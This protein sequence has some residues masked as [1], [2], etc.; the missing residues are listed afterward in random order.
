VKTKDFALDVK[1]VGEDGVFSGYGSV[2]HVEDRQKEIV[3]PGAFAK[4]LGR[5]K[6]SGE[7]PAMLRSHNPDRPI[8]VWTDM[9]EDSRG[10]YVEGRLLINDV[11][12]A[13]ET[14]ALM[15]ARAMRGLSI[16][17]ASEIGDM[18]KGVWNIAD[19]D[20]MEVSVVAIPANPVAQIDTV[21]SWGGQKPSLSQFEDFLREAGGFS[22]SEAKAIASHGLKHLLQRE[23]GD[24]VDQAAV[25]AIR[26]LS[27]RL[28]GFSLPR[29]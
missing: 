29:L 2:F 27:A 5:A 21:K 25:D 20:L 14:H 17:Y 16:G 15:K 13:R 23:A 10:L 1:S 19:V 24:G 3:L 8:G 26:G 12:D 7:M 6:S 9:K 11:Q 22:R 4:S 18:V 28:D